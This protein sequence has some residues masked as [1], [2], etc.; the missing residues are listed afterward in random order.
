MKN[1]TKSLIAAAVLAATST[2]AMA[3]VSMNVGATSNYI[4]RGVSQT[5]DQAAISGGLD[6]A[7]DSG[8][9]AGTWASNVDFDGNGG[10]AYE[11]DLYAGFGGKAGAFG[12]DAGFISYQYP[13]IEDYFHE[14][15]FNGSFDMFSFGV[16]YTAGSEDD[17]TPAFSSGDIYY[18]AGLENEVSEGITL[19]A[20]VG[21]YN[22]DDDLAEDYTHFAVSVSKS[23]FTLAIEKNDLTDSGAGEDNPRVTVS[24][25]QSF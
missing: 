20:T 24:W 12:Y 23:D 21:S 1:M 22:F 11:L 18:Y 3:E 10:G 16:A 25:S 4:W 17:N 9:Y 14:V 7:H 8:F 15:Y 6:Y 2:A 13:V 5:M 19:G